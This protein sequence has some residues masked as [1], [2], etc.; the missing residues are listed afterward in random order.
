MWRNLW[1]VGMLCFS[2]YHAYRRE[3]ASFT[4]TAAAVHAGLGPEI[5]LK[6][7]IWGWGFEVLHLNVR[8]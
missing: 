8:C 2:G 3:I 1:Q 7:G 6:I 5:G 4:C